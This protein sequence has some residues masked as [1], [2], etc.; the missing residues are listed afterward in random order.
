MVK[1][2]N[3]LKSK[4]KTQKRYTLLMFKEDDN[5]IEGIDLEKLSED[6]IKELITLNKEEIKDL[7]NN[8]SEKLKE[9]NK[10]FIKKAYRRFLK[11]NIINELGKTESTTDNKER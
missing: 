3:Y 1:Q 8:S 2:F 6:E 4:D 10:K 5:Y 7:L 11:K 9:K